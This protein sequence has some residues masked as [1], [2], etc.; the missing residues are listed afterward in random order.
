M[1]FGN[2]SIYIP[3][4]QSWLEHGIQNFVTFKHLK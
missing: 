1:Q 2:P 3:A 4:L